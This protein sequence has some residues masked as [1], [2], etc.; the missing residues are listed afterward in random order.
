MAFDNG[1][2]DGKPQAGALL[3]GAENAVEGVDNALALAWGNAGA[4]VFYP[5]IEVFGGFVKT[6]IDAAAFGSIADGVVGK[7]FDEG[8][9]FGVVGVDL[10]VV[11]NG[12]ADVLTFGQ[13]QRHEFLQDA[14]E[15]VLQADQGFGALG[16]GGLGACEGKEL[17]E[18]VAVALY[19][20]LQQ[21]GLLARFGGQLHIV[22][23]LCL[24][25]KGG[26]GAAQFVCGIGDKA[27][28]LADVFVGTLQQVVDSDDKAL[29]FAGNVLRV[30]RR[31][32]VDLAL[33]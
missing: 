10:A 12:D 19:A 30:H 14:A 23:P 20:L 33:F 31:E 8:V 5:D 28:L 9:D 13:R 25:G 3:F 26:H 6:Q 1:V 16:F 27:L 4:V 18:Q 32:V 21:G 17:L 2:C 7:G 22:E 11:F 24:K 15:L 29:D